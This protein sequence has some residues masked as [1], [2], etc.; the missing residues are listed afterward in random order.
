MHDLHGTRIQCEIGNASAGQG[1]G[2]KD[3]WG[4]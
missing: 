3:D 1:A 4:V 2:G